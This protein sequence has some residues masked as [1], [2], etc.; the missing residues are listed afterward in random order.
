VAAWLPEAGWRFVEHTQL[1]GPQSLIVA[2][3]V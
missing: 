2:E 3:A 1:A